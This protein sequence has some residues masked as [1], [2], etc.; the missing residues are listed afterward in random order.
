[1]IARHGVMVRR[2]IGVLSR[3]EA[4]NAPERY[5]Y[6]QFLHILAGNHARLASAAAI[7]VKVKSESHFDYL[8]TRCR[9]LAQR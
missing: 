8:P 7:L 9:R 1:M 6:G 2:S 4:E 3:L 5:A